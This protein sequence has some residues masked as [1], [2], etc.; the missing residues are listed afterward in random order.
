MKILFLS[1]FLL[2]SCGKEDKA[3][4]EARPNYVISD[5]ISGFNWRRVDGDLNGRQAFVTI[6][7][8]S[9]YF[10]L[11]R[12]SYGPLG[13]GNGVISDYQRDYDFKA[14]SEKELLAHP[15]EVNDIVLN[16]TFEPWDID[17]SKKV[18]CINSNC[19]VY[20]RLNEG[21]L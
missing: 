9:D 16:V 12:Y 13:P 14:L 17:A 4:S 18:I 11:L 15:R 2:V 21:D 20:E 19:N 7:M 1:V 5:D 3:S 10:G 6:V 8:H